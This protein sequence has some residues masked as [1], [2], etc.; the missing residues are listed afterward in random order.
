MKN[1]NLE[2][3]IVKPVLG[4]E[5][6]IANLH[7]QT[8]LATYPN[9]GCGITPQDI[10][11]KDFTSEKKLEIWRQRIKDNRHVCNYLLVAKIAGRIV[12]FCS[13]LKKPDYGEINTVYVLP[14][15]Q[16]RG[17]GQKLFTKSL[18]W[19]KTKKKVFI[20]CAEYNHKAISFYEKF[21]FEKTGRPAADCVLPNGK[22]IKEIELVLEK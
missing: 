2:I 8:W 19:L 21:G 5:I 15:F 12:G 6:A 7:R 11:L 4:D 20:K 1:N 17:V 10:S 9:V 16:G 18:A 3:E 22:I 13:A 14:E